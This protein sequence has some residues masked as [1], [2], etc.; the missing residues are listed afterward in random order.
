MR[1]GKDVRR[2]IEKV[3]ALILVTGLLLTSMISCGEPERKSKTYYDYFDTFSTLYSF[4]DD[5]DDVFSANAEAF[6]QEMATCHKLFD[7]YN[8]YSGMNN[9]KTVNDMAGKG[10]VKVD[11]RIIDLLSFSKEMYAKTA[12]AVNVAMGSVLRIWHECREDGKKVPTEEEL[13]LASV[14]CDIEKLVIDKAN[15]TVELLDPEMSLDVG[16]VAK[17]FAI[18]RAASILRS[19]GAT[20]YALDVGGNIYAIGEKPDGTLFKTGVE[21]PDGGDYPAYIDVKNGAVATSGDYQRY[22]T[23]GGVTYHH[24]INGK[25]LFP[26]NYHRSVSV[27]SSSAALSDALSTAIFNT[28][29]YDTAINMIRSIG[30]VREV[31]FITKDGGVKRITP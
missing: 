31:I 27:Y 25:T 11:G 17:G 12:G 16:A 10:A 6:R 4:A 24:I 5:S 19:R 1:K 22:Y 28:E 29:S 18:D 20:S 14:H 15:G 23:V 13:S 9:I 8:S 7:I 26:S 21:N 3:S 2:G 30:G